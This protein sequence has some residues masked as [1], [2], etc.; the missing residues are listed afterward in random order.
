MSLQTI[1]LF[2]CGTSG[3]YALTNDRSGTVLPAAGCCPAG[4]HFERSIALP[5][6]EALPKS[7]L[8]RATLSAIARHGYY[9][10]DAAITGLP[11]AIAAD[12]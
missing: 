4:W 10:S 9:L 7:E 5:P 1:H 6:Q 3:L 12:L 2:R 8:L 11:L